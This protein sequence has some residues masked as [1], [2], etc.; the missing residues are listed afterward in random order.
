MGPLLKRAAKDMA[1]WSDTKL[2]KAAVAVA[3][4]GWDCQASQEIIEQCFTSLGHTV[5]S[6][7]ARLAKLAGVLL[8]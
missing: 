2:A 8:G 1:T 5:P 6:P 3:E 7:D 4:A